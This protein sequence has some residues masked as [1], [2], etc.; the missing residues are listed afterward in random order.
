MSNL[1]TRSNINDYLLNYVGYDA[2]E[3]LLMPLYVKKELVEDD[4][5]SFLEYINEE[6]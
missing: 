5:D 6:Q 3:L 1:L 4:M 2:D